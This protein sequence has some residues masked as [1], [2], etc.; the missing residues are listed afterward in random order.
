[1]QELISLRIPSEAK[2]IIDKAA[3]YSNCS[4]NSFILS[5]AIEKAEEVIQHKESIVLSSL[6]AKRLCELLLNP[7][8][9]NEALK[10]LMQINNG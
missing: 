2:Y 8:E 5:Q 6:E 1:M 4:R 3:E 7:P 10:K 9:A